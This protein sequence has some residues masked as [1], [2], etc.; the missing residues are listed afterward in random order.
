MLEICSFQIIWRLLPLLDHS[1]FGL[2]LLNHFQ[3]S[4]HKKRQNWISRFCFFV[5]LE[6]ISYLG[7]DPGIFTG[8]E[9]GFNMGPP[10]FGGN[11]GQRNPDKPKDLQWRF[12]T[13]MLMV[14]NGTT[15]A[16]PENIFHQQLFHQIY[17]QSCQHS[18]LMVLLTFHPTSLD[19]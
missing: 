10:I 17:Q 3:V 5:P 1:C 14:A 12:S 18:L 7:D 6:E 16:I 9:H 8:G 2:L 4:W 11:A 15:G 13:N 19:R